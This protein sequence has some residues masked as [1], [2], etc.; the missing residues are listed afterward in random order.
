MLISASYPSIKNITL[1]YTL[2][3]KV[4]RNMGLRDLR[5]SMSADNL[6]MF[7]HL[8]GMNPQYSFTGGTTYVYAPSRTISFGVDVKF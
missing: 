4:I 1:G 7:T 5:F 2:P 3:S 6:Y 8:K